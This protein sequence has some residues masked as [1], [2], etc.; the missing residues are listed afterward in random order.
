AELRGIP[1]L[2]SGEAGGEGEP[3]DLGAG[4]QAGPR[5]R[6][7]VRLSGGPVRRGRS[8]TDDDRDRGRTL[9]LQHAEGRAHPVYP[10]PATGGQ[11]EGRPEGGYKER[12]TLTT[13]ARV[14]CR[15][16]GGWP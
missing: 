14:L 8:E 7:R 10:S 9:P 6:D 5:H 16:P 13:A 4:K 1:R 3:G 15:S 11:V 12:A 2:H